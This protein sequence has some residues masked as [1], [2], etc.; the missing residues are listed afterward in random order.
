MAD[1][2]IGYGRPPRHSQFKKGVCANPSGRPRR[3][4]AEIG[5]VVRSFLS[6]DAQYRERG[7]TRKTSRLELVIKRHVAGALNGDIGSAAM[8]LKM[9]AR[10]LRSGDIG[11]LI[12]RIE[13]SLPPFPYEV[14]G[15]IGS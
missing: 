2:E 11:P 5:D 7:R 12:I 15:E 4:N 10:A 1:Y 6:A 13:N 8:L 9:R 3:C 14:D